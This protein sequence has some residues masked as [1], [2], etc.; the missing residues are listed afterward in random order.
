MR[1]VGVSWKNR[2][3]EAIAR[4]DGN[5][6]QVMGHYETYM[7][8]TDTVAKTFSHDPSAVYRKAGALKKADDLMDKL[9]V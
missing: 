4:L 3:E 1:S 5:Y 9:L 7:D 2:I 6:E 8:Q